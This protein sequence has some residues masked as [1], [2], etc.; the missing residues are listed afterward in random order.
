MC[1]GV[2]WARPPK[3]G[4]RSPSVCGRTLCW[5]VHYWTPEEWAG[6]KRMAVA[7]LATLYAEQDR[8]AE[9]WTDPVLGV[10]WQFPH[11]SELDEEAM[12]RG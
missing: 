1:Q 8:M 4:K 10:R 3:K 7:L 12:R 11:W 9:T 6:R 2:Y 5:A